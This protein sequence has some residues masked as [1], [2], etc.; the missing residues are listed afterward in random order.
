VT[1]QMF[2]SGGQIGDN[3]TRMTKPIPMELVGATFLDWKECC[4]KACVYDQ[5]VRIS[6][7]FV[8]AIYALLISKCGGT[9]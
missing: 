3:E 7:D 1:D 6:F 2:S 5:P 8:V 9:R 4:N